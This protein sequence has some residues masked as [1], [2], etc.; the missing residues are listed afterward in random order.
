MDEVEGGLGEVVGRELMSPHLETGTIDGLQ[1]SR[2][3]V[4]RYNPSGWSHARTEPCGDAA[5]T[6]AELQTVP[7]RREA[8]IDQA[9][10]RA[11]VERIF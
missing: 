4:S 2:V 10:R 3:D 8:Q 6:G 1:E 9:P 5:A 7:T 11:R